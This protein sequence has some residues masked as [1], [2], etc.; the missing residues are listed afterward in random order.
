[1]GGDAKELA[2]YE[3]RQRPSRPP[4]R[5]CNEA[6]GCRR[7]LRQFRAVSVDQ[8]VGIDRDQDRPSMCS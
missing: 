6:L 3:D 4:F 8:D 1:M 2:E 7:V 5:Q